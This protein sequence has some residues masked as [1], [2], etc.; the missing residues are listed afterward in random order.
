MNFL[1]FL[2]FFRQQN[3]ISQSSSIIYLQD[4]GFEKNGKFE[5]NFT[6]SKHDSIFV[7]IANPSESSFVSNLAL[8]QDILN[9]QNAM[10]LFQIKYSKIVNTEEGFGTYS[11]TI[12]T[13]TYY[14]PVFLTCDNQGSHYSFTATFT[15]PTSHLDYRTK[16]C[17]Y[18]KP[19]FACLFG[20]LL[21]LWLINWF[22]NFTLKNSLHMYL[23]LTMI[24][25]LVYNIINFFLIYHNHIS[26]DYTYLTPVSVT[27]RGLQELCILSAMMMAAKGWCIIMS[28]IDWKGILISLLY[29]LLFIVPILLIDYFFFNMYAQVFLL[30][31][32]LVGS[33]SYYFELLKSIRAANSV[34]I[35]HLLVISQSGINPETT[36]IYAKCKMFKAISTAV[37]AY[38]IILMFKSLFGN[39]IIIPFWIISLFYDII[40]LALISTA[41][42]L[43]KLKKTTKN[44]YMMVGEENDQPA[45]FSLE[46]IEHINVSSEEM[47]QGTTVWHEGMSLPAQPIL[48]H[49]SQIKDDLTQHLN[50]N[51]NDNPD[52]ND[53][54]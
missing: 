29:S 38:F 1:I 24:L 4:F 2:V 43:F 7:G 33:M 49:S 19:V 41:A 18:T 45:E 20:I 30:F 3:K 5:I 26:D 39:I 21:I 51:G 37:L 17:I 9:C 54:L 52:Q 53:K 13:K 28:S 35:A 42:W 22:F 32:G 40:T 14:S 31:L 46:D 6:S 27:L 23:T 44:G 12:Q 16:P 48:H 11:G 25:T 50:P 36:P 34:V 8:S 15:N 47:K 10:Q